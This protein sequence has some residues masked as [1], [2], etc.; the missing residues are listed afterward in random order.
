MSSYLTHLTSRSSAGRIPA[1]LQNVCR[2]GFAVKILKTTKDEIV[3]N[4]ILHAKSI[5]IHI[6]TTIK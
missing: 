2:A 4:Q 5:Q 1:A 6:G 3:A